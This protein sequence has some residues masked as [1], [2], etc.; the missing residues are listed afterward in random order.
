MGVD[1]SENPRDATLVEDAW[2]V[3]QLNREIED[4]LVESRDRFPT[5][6]VGEIAEVDHYGFGTFFELR[7]LEADPVISCLSWSQA[8]SEFEHELKEGTEA[9]VEASV[10]FYPDRGAC[11]LLVTGYWPLGESK[12]QQKLAKLRQQLD[13][14]GLFDEDRKQPI[15]SYPNCIGLVTSPSGSAREDAW[16]AINSRSPRTTVKLF[17]ATVQG[18]DAVPSMIS[19]INHLDA[20]SEV[21][22]IIVTRGGGSDADLWCFNAE[23][24][25]RCIAACSTPVIVAIGHEDDETLAEYVGDARAMTPTKAGVLATTPFEDVLSHLTV[26]EDRMLWGYRSVVEDR[27]GRLAQRIVTAYEGLEQRDSHLQSLRQRARDLEQRITNRYTTVVDT[28]LDTLDT[29]IDQALKEVEL[30]TEAES[31]SAR[32]AHGRLND[33]ERR[34]NGAYQ[35]HIDRELNSIDHRIE[36]AYRNVEAEARIEAGTA[37]ARRLRLVVAVLVVLLILLGLG[38]AFVLL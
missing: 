5:H 18:E 14:D 3:G 28:R 6:I 38:I 1:Q 35:T 36:T 29:R 16:A 32:V 25:V 33:L 21:E 20:D 22:T 37:Q 15:P 4:A 19:G 26:I 34:V 2:S 24:L 30:A 27:V 12:R 17:G 7:D 10:D 8:V 31:A 13:A 23:P 11:Q 9:I